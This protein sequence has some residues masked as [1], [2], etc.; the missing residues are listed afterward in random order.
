ME[1]SLRASVRG[2]ELVDQARKR[3]GWNRQSAA[4]A[5]AALTSVASLKQFWRRERISRETFIRICEAVGLN[6][7]QEIAADHF[8]EQPVVVDWGEAPEPIFF[9]GRH[10]E[11]ETL[12]RWIRGDGCKLVALLGM[13]GMGKTTLAVRLVQQLVGQKA[14]GEEDTGTR[15]QGDTETFEIQNSKFKI[16]NS[17]PTPFTHIIWRSLRNAPQL[18]AL[19][20]DL[21]RFFGGSKQVDS[22]VTDQDS[23]FLLS[24]L[25]TDL[26]EYRCLVVLDNAESILV[27][28]DFA[29]VGSYHSGYENYGELLRRIG[30]ERH[31]SCLV[32]TSREQPREFNLLDGDRVRS[33]RLQGL[34]QEEGQKILERVGA[35]ST[36][37]AECRVIVDHYAGNP[38]ALKLAAAGIR[39]LLHGNVG[40]FLS[41]LQQGRLLFGDIRDLLE[42][43][44]NPSLR[45]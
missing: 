30:E 17:P 15:R 39:D 27:G 3:K 18:E 34:P 38:L 12:D 37:V 4:W 36:S 22:G 45:S 14:E 8:L 7:W 21:L 9:C 32:L 1:D 20:T 2:L 40:E 10:Q 5:Q 11:L 35:F 16:Q 44:F 43:H 6:S 33:L 41:L 24:K 28:E 42:R 13:G 26:R 23:A 29:G 25:L 19:L 31:Q